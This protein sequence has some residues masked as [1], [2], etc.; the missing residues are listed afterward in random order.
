M[1]DSYGFNVKLVEGAN[2]GGRANGSRLNDRGD[3]L[4]DNRGSGLLLLAL[5]RCSGSECGSICVTLLGAERS[6]DGLLG[7][8]LTIGLET[9]FTSAVHDGLEDASFINV[10][11]LAADVTLGSARLHL[12]RAVSSFEA[13]GV[14]AVIVHPVDLLQDGHRGGL[15]ADVSRHHQSSNNL[16]HHIEFTE[17]IN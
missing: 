3:L 11:V 8:V 17:L 9:N 5:R 12:E 15:A 4:G 14:R 7:Q 6:R 16:R 10:T 1:K 2:G 13:V